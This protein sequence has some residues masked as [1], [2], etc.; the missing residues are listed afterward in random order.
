[1]GLQAFNTRNFG[2]EQGGRANRL[3][4]AKQ[5]QWRGAGNLPQLP[6]APPDAAGLYLFI[7]LWSGI[8]TA[9]IAM[10]AMGLRLIAVGAEHDQ[11]ARD[12]CRASMPSMMH[13]KKVENVKAVDFSA[14]LARRGVH[15]NYRRGG[16]PCQGNASL[17]S[18]RKGL[19]DP[20]SSQPQHLTRLHAEFE[21]I[22]KVSV[23]T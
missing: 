20:R 6:W 10:L 22:C 7:E 4:A 18:S 11:D 3:A 12:A 13:Y 15:G 16:S 14:L 9:A 8:G 19:V 21:S 1:M 17:N 23:L 5:L 2:H